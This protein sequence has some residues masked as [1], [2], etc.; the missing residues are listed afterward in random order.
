MKMKKWFSLVPL[1]LALILLAACGPKSAEDII[2][3]E[4]KDSYT[5]YA[6]L[7]A[8]ESF[9]NSGGEQLKFAPSEKQISN[10]SGEIVYFKTISE[11][12]LPTEAS[13]VLTSLEEELKNTNNFTIAIS[14]KREKLDAS[15][16]YYQ[17]SLSDGGDKIRIIE[18]RR[19]HF[20]EGGYYDF[21]GT[22]E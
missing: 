4:L 3:T 20:A 15:D 18:L 10:S 9:F 12:D 19:N 1:G 22:A 14:K 13:G 16:A 21:S 5:G 17:I 2:K 8:Y 6:E 11:S 7:R